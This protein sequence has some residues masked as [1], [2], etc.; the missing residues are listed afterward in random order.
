MASQGPQSPGTAGNNSGVGSID[1]SSP[2]NAKVSDN[3]YATVSPS[4]FDVLS[5]YLTVSNFGF[6]IP[7]GATINGITVEI[8]R[9]ASANGV[10]NITDNSVKIIKSSGSLGATNKADTVSLWP[11][12]DAFATY[13]SAADVWGETWLSSDI[14][15]ANFGV[16]IAVNMNYSTTVT[17]SIDFIRITVDY[18][19][20]S[21]VPN[22]PNYATV[23]TAGGDWS[24]ITNAQGGPDGLTADNFNQGP[25]GGGHSPS[26]L[27][28][29]GFGF[30][31]PTTAVVD[32]IK[33]E[34]KV[35]GNAGSSDQ[36]I[37]VGKPAK[38]ST[39][40]PNFGQVWPGV[41]GFL[42]WGGATSLWGR[43]DWTPA[44]INDSTFGA[45]MSAFAATG[46][47]TISIDA[48]RMTVY[49]HTAPTEVPKTYLYKVF[50]SAGN[51]LGNLPNVISEFGYTVD[52]N[53]AGTNIN[54]ECAVSADTSQLSTD[55]LTDES[56][57]IL[58]DESSV[59]LTN[60]GVA[61]QVALGS[62]SN[63]AL[64][65][66]GN[67]IQVIETSY[68]NPNG[69]SMFLGQIGK[70]A[71]SY[72]G[73]NNSQDTVKII[74]YGDGQD[75]DNYLVR[76]NPYT[77]T[78]DVTQTSQ[79]S[80]YDVT[81]IKAG[82]ARVGQTWK[83][84]AGVTN[85]GAISLLL[86]GSAD[87]TLSVYDSPA[88][89][90]FLGSIIQFVSAAGAEVQFGFANTIPTTPGS[91][92]FFGISVGD[93]Q[94]MS[95]YYQNTDV[96]A[97]GSKWSASYGGGGGG[98]YGP[99][100][101]QDLYFKT[102]SGSGSTIGTYTSQDPTTGMLV[103]FMNDYIARGG[104]L[105]YST[106][107]A[108]GLSLT[109]TFNTN[110]IYEGVRAVLSLSPNG[111][112]WYVDLGTDTLYFKQASTTADITLVKG[113]HLTDLNIVA[114]IEN[115]KN[116]VY[117][118]GGVVA[119][120]NIYVQ[121]SNSSSIGM[122]GI[123]LDRQSDNH[124]TDTTTARSVAVA[125]ILKTKDE[126][127]QTVATILDKTLDT[128]TLRPGL[129]IGFT[130]FGTFVDSLLMQIVNVRY[131]PSEVTVTLG[132]LPK[133]ISPV[134]EALTRGLL[135]Q[136]TIANPSVPS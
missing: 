100:S 86:N 24:T 115:I 16:A 5:H 79:N 66:N 135:A 80:T 90:T 42:T 29:S 2:N 94:I 4:P 84:G 83:V 118:S 58:T 130:G 47:G 52:I 34:A 27:V 108:T 105:T 97:N 8:E 77:Y 106:P 134:L 63:D 55:F 114:S 76:G 109:Y 25:G 57:N 31:I 11:T 91:T 78:G 126:Q 104:I 103:P 44:D 6:T 127:Y 120:S 110:T 71:A 1:W 107:A 133:R 38:L 65:K 131:S 53:S 9:K 74:C 82:Y 101:S 102:F 62:D 10:N 111:F 49:W 60:E 59:N 64:I 96:Y 13:G 36:L 136:Q 46:T 28:T 92:L 69:K 7:A 3:A 117:F 88:Q 15:N 19:P 129:I 125:S 113:V 99:D 20:L 121:A 81:Q 37:Q 132:I 116:S 98:G 122:Y 48:V 93:G 51:Y 32:G 87:V 68:W 123:R 33:L 12:S 119:G 18:T 112:Y 61:P 73:D 43:T 50:N 95:V 72:G 54:I 39:S 14:N 23:A 75:L 17:A 128:S 56:G 22:G 67:T 35:F 85:L 45:S 89:T 26:Q 70:W 124:V 21:P 30:S 40:S 41:L